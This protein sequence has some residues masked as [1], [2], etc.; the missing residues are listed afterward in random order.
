MPEE[1]SDFTTTSIA[2]II[3]NG[4][5]EEIKMLLGGR[6]KIRHTG[7]IRAGKRR[8]LDSCT[9]Q[10]KALFSQLEAEG[11]SYDEVDRKLGGKPKTRESKLTTVNTDHFVIREMDFKRPADAEFILKNYA[12]ADGKVRRVPVFFT[13]SD[14]D[15]AI[16]HGYTAF[17]GSSNLRCKSFYD[18]D[19][20][21]FRYLEK[22]IT[23]P[24]AGDWKIL[25]SDDE[26][27]ATRACGY[28]VTFSGMYRVNVVGLRGIGEVIIPNKSWNGMGDAVAVLNKIKKRL[29]RFD[30]LLNGQSFFELCKVQDLVKHKGKKVKQWIITLELSVDPMEI[31][32]YTEPTQVAARAQHA[33]RML[34]G[35]TAAPPAPQPSAVPPVG[36]PSQDQAETDPKVKAAIT[37]LEEMVGKANIT[38]EQIRSYVVFQ[39]SGQCL[40]DMTVDELTAVY[41][42]VR[43]ELHNDRDVFVATVNDIHRDQPSLSDDL[44]FGN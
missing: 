13:V 31:E 28:K 38:P 17:D 25:D 36:A 37:A 1:V 9:A 32:R 16:P 41:K 18:G 39:Y 15:K 43:L 30:G 3:E 7:I 42:A 14:I 29:G 11:L 27:E 21:K 5:E 19:D 40:D 20:L 22:S 4:S 35:R 34:T 8:P 10:E 33:M 2:H 6:D 12:D 26:D 23:A 44:P 24:K